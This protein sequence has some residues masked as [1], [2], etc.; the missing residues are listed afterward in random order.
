MNHNQKKQQEDYF[1]K[2]LNFSN[3]NAIYFWPA[4]NATYTIVD[5]KFSPNNSRSRKAMISTT[6]KTFQETYMVK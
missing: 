2:V 3:P 5:G 1:K 4:E 6:G